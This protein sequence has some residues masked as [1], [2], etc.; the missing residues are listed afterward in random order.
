MFVTLMSQVTDV[1]KD[2]CDAMSMNFASH[3]S[4]VTDETPINYSVT[5]T[6]ASHTSQIVP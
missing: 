6:Q 5:F 1:T 3:L 4:F 2:S